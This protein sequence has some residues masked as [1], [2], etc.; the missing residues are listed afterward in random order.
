MVVNQR[1]SSI[2]GRLPS[3]VV[4]RQRSSSVKGRLLSNVVFRQM[5]SSIKCRLP[6]RLPSKVVF[7]QRSSSVKGRLP[8]KVVFRDWRRRFFSIQDEW[9]WVWAETTED[10]RVRVR[11]NSTKQRANM[12]FE[13]LIFLLSVVLHWWKYIPNLKVSWSALIITFIKCTGFIYTILLS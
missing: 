11:Q 9:G 7:F 5:S 10:E 13:C 6:G 1:S 2:K 4:F 3:K 12:T 8:S